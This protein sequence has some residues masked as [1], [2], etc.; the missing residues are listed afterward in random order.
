MIKSENLKVKIFADGAI[1]EDMVALYANP[2]IKGFTT[3]PTLM[4]RAGVPDYEAF[5]KEAVAAIPDRPISFEVFADDAEGMAA[6]ALK[7]NGWGDNLYIKIPITNTKG[8]SCVP[9]I[10][11]LAGEGVKINVTAL[12]T[13]RQV[14]ETVAVLGDSPSC[15]ISLFAGRI[16][17]SG[18]DPLPIMTEALRI[19]APYRQLELVWASPREVFNIVQAGDIGCHIIT[20]TYDLLKKTALF[21]K[22]LNEFSLETVRMFHHDALAAG[23]RL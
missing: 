18:V 2:L 1:I 8:E 6:Q 3:N 11:R 7:I 9:L 19:M 23:Y 14:E 10:R 17:D 16:A 12:M 15:Y 21:G 5:A 13:A 20:V 4:R 22:D